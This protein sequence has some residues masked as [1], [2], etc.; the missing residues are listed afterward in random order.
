[1][2]SQ[3][4]AARSASP[5]S[6]RGS[7]SAGV[8]H[9]MAF[10]T[11]SGW[12]DDTSSLASPDATV[13]SVV[14]E[15]VLPSSRQVSSQPV[16]AQP[17]A[18]LARTAT[19]PSGSRKIVSYPR[20]VDRDSPATSRNATR[21]PSTLGHVDSELSD[22]VQQDFEQ[23]RVPDADVDR[24]VN[25]LL[26]LEFA[27]DHEVP[28][29]DEPRDEVQLE[30]HKKI[31]QS[32]IKQQSRYQSTQP[33]TFDMKPARLAAQRY[34]FE[35]IE[36][37]CLELGMLAKPETSV[38]ST[39]LWDPSRRA[40]THNLPVLERLATIPQVHSADA[41]SQSVARRLSFL[42]NSLPANHPD[43]N[44]PRTFVTSVETEQE[45]K[46]KTHFGSSCQKPTERA[47]VGEILNRVKLQ[48]LIAEAALVLAEL[49]KTVAPIKQDPQPQGQQQTEEN[50]TSTYTAPEFE[51]GHECEPKSEPA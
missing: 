48:K 46:P 6:K 36:R 39:P 24:Q 25:E 34:N 29:V 45:F 5:P 1:M 20:T 10:E 15:T 16:F 14:Q 33:A 38:L 21:W 22:I 27:R 41:S 4:P 13:N 28:G 42:G 47:S 32:T 18:I 40:P 26:P 12:S 19:V 35:A 11:E 49:A 51:C 8:D 3:G 9:E 31:Q 2:L 30:K 50:R 17:Q 37:L 23:S 43:P 44:E 7:K